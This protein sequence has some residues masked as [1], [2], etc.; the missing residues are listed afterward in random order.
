MYV[1]PSKIRLAVIDEI[2]K[3]SLEW[4]EFYNG[5][6]LD[7]YGM[8]HIESHMNPFT[9]VVDMASKTAVIPATGNEPL[10]LTYTHDLGKF[11]VAALDLPQWKQSFGVYSENITWN[12]F[13]KRAEKVVGQYN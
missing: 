11:V 5:F 8:P 7:Y 6:F 13:I 12:E 9:F 4:T 3:T 1:P 2:R 10:S